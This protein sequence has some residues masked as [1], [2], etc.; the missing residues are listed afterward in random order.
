MRTPVT[1]ALFVVLFAIAAFFMCSGVM[2]WARNQA[3][4]K[5]YEDVFLT[6]GTVRQ[7][8]A[9][10]EITERWDAFLKD[11]IRRSG[12]SYASV[13][14][15]SVL[16]FEGAGYVLGPE[17]RPFY[18]AWRPDL[19]L[20]PEDTRYKVH[21]LLVVEVTPLADCVPDHPVEVRI[22]R[23]LNEIPENAFLSLKQGEV[24]FFCDHYNDAPQPLL[25]GKTYLTCIR[26]NGAFDPQDIYAPVEYS[27]PT[28]N[29]AFSSQYRPDGTLA[30]DKLSLPAIQEVTDGF[31]ETQAGRLW[32]AYAD[33]LFAPYRTVP[34]LPT[35]ATHLLLPF[36]NET[37]FIAEGEDISPEEYESGARVCLVSANFAKM[38]GLSPETRCVCRFTMP[39]M[40]TCQTTCFRNPTIRPR[41]EASSPGCRRAFE[42]RRRAVCR[43]LRPRVCHQGHLYKHVREGR[44]IRHGRQYHRDPGGVGAGVRRGQHPRLR[45]MQDTTTTF[46]IPNGSIETFMERWLS[47]GNEELE[48][49]FYDRGYTQLQRGLENMKRISLLFMAIGAVLSLALVFFFCHVFVSKN[50]MRTAVERMLGYTRKQCAVSLLSGF[51]LAAAIAISAG[52]A[53]GI[54]AEGRITAG[55]TSQTYYDTSFTV[56]PMGRDGVALEET[57]VSAL[58]SPGAGL[59]LL[60]VTGLISAVFLRGNVSEEPLK[61]LG[62]RIE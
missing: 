24:V 7:R 17:K 21:N 59:A 13:I 51:L 47:Q 33:A 10:I 26:S 14:P 42:H 9:S 11:Y 43:F 8:A 1:T 34:V 62:G 30:E 50:K 61:L 32:L 44:R 60:L 53:A 58:Y 6:I 31:Y 55:L 16:D 3:A 4:M 22:E 20:W 35:A 27:P 54:V 40:K 39:T 28:V 23:V 49:T 29:L 18:G 45:P 12:P 2:I 56:G 37:A 38:N 25:A 46:Q 5:A 57:S 52:C 36:Y 41:L 15:A 48:F 19:R